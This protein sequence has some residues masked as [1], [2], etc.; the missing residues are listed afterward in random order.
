VWDSSASYT[1]LHSMVQALCRSDELGV[2]VRKV[3][4][5]LACR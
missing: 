2:Q 1:V 5:L 4:I 3:D